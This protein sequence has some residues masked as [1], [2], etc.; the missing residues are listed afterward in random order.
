MNGSSPIQRRNAASAC[1]FWRLH[2]LVLLCSVPCSLAGDLPPGWK[3]VQ[4]L[5]FRVGLPPGWK[6]ERLPGEE[7]YDGHFVGDGASLDIYYGYLS[8]SFFYSYNDRELSIRSETIFENNV[9]IATP[10][11]P[12]VG[13]T[14]AFFDNLSG[15]SRLIVAGRNL[16]PSQQNTAVAIFRTIQVQGTGPHNDTVVVSQRR[17]CLMFKKTQ[18][19]SWACTGV[20]QPR[21]IAAVTAG[22]A[23]AVERLLNGFVDVN[24][25][26]ALSGETAL[27]LAA[28]GGSLKIVKLLVAARADLE[29][30]EDSWGWTPLMRAANRGHLEV[31]KFLVESG[32]DTKKKDRDQKTAL[33]HAKDHGHQDV[34]AYLNKANP[35]K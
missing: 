13:V 20:T 1:I 32:A 14:G 27:N 7:S 17:D 9:V 5:G 11:T 2:F 12:G 15:Q 6:Y 8:P 18:M 16:S 21:L 3:P 26:S 19:E 25:Q 23:D 4:N 22:N 30:P 10:K 35:Q 31:V 24:E 34:V 29:I 28:F 33:D